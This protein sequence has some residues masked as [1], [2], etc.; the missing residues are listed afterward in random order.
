MLI[1]LKIV[2]FLTFILLIYF[3]EKDNFFEKINLIYYVITYTYKKYMLYNL[4]P[5]YLSPKVFM[6]M[7]SII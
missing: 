5:V 4:Q 3:Y 7:L 6:Y 1:L 2:I